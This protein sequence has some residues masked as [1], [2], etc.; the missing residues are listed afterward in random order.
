MVFPT[1]LGK[2]VVDGNTVA[3]AAAAAGVQRAL[4]PR[5]V[6][7]CPIEGDHYSLHLVGGE[8]VVLVRSSTTTRAASGGCR[9]Q[10]PVARGGQAPEQEQ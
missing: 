7:S 5:I 3:A 8:R 6:D 4:G 1:D 2:E 9:C 10:S